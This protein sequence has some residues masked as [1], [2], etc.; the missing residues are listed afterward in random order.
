M[1]ENNK[2]DATICK[3]SD[4]NEQDSSDERSSSEVLCILSLKY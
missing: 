1:F 3:D 4:E 2:E